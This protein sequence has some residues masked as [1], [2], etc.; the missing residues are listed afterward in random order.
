[1]SLRVASTRLVLPLEPPD[2][3][4]AADRLRR[5]EERLAGPLDPLWRRAAQGEPQVELELTALA[6]G[7]G[8]LLFSPLLLSA[9]AGA[10]ARERSAGGELTLAVSGGRGCHGLLTTADDRL[11]GLEDWYAPVPFAEDAADRWADAV[12]AVTGRLV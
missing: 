4:A 7:D 5:A 10:L 12:A 1:A 11:I 6:V 9:S 3:G 2:A 8:L